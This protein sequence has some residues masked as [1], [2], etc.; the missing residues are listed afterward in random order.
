[1]QRTRNHI[2]A[3]LETAIVLL[4]DLSFQDQTKFRLAAAAIKIIL[5]ENRNITFRVR[6]V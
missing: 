3:S 1:M 2:F 6:K 5:E 4:V